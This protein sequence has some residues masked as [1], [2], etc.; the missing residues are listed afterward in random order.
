MLILV[1]FILIV[2][3]IFYIF[4]YL[5][6]IWLEQLHLLICFRRMQVTLTLE[7]L[8]CFAQILCGEEDVFD[9]MM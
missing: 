4:C 3:E 6:Y 2:Y 9:E 7:I 8:P 1:L 5:K